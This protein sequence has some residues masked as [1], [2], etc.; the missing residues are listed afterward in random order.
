VLSQLRTFFSERLAPGVDDDPG[1]RR[2]L[3]AAA[4]LIEIARADFEFDED[5]QAE[6]RGVLATTLDLR[7]DEIEEIVQLA[8]AESRDA[9]SLH[10]FTRLVNES[11]S[12]EDKLRLMEDLWRVA[13]ADGH[14]D[15]H[16]EQLLRRIA[17]LLHL[18]HAEFMKAKHAAAPAD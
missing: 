1:H 18:R 14:I 6:I 7:A 16:E 8:T 4:L 5:E 13:Y 3:A 2:H 17:D 12:L 11:H 10:Q 9:I 15:K